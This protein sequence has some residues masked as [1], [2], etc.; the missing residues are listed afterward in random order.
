[1]K[2]KGIKEYLKNVNDLNEKS[3]LTWNEIMNLIEYE[4]KNDIDPKYLNIPNI[5]F[6]LLSKENDSCIYEKQ[7]KERGF[8][9]SETWSLTDTIVAFILPRLK[10]YKELLDLNTDV[11]SESSEKIY[12]IIK[13]FEII[14]E[15]SVWDFTKKEYDLID[16]G[17]KNF[18]E[19]FFSLWW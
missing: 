7:R 10:R 14:K 9:D 1:M 2:E 17:L 12:S 5:S 19:M 16:I 3:N 15:H 4:T 6:S 8:D 18:N 11:D 13:C